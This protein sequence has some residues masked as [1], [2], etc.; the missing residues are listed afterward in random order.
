M[1]QYAIGAPFYAKQGLTV[2]QL[3]RA[4]ILTADQNNYNPAGLST[5]GILQIKSN[6]SPRNITGLQAPTPQTQSGRQLL[7]WNLSAGFNI[8]LKQGSASSSA[9][10]Q[11][12][13]PG[14][15]DYTLAWGHSVLLY[16]VYDYDGGL[17]AKWLVVG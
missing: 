6:A 7:L 2:G 15:T 8:T 14:E 9:A 1:R 10:N 16:Y 17:N 12:E 5:A 11:F 13:C 3:V 4:P